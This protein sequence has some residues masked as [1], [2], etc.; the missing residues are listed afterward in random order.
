MEKVITYNGVK[1][2]K[3]P[4][5]PYFY[6]SSN[7]RVKQYSSAL[8]RQMWFD[9]F[10]EIPDGFE[11]H[12]KDHD[13]FNNVPENLEIMSK[14]D[15]SSHHQSQP[16]KKEFWKNVIQPKGVEAAKEWHGSDD[17]LQW[18]RDHAAKHNFG[19][20]D[21]GTDKCQVCGSE[22]QRKTKTAKFCS[23]KC[24][25]QYR[26]DNK[27]DVVTKQ[28]DWCSNEFESNK[29]NKTIFCSRSCQKSAY[30]DK[31]KKTDLSGQNESL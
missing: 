24:K 3:H 31:R 10:G 23:N 16:D 30:W 22:Y 7:K 12:H 8:H 2:Y 13:A 27:L 14:S 6:C 5:Q 18:H 11:V 28:C 17:G 4:K 9:N 25:S 1:Y 15:H 21:F 19:K 29:Y 26:R 20:F